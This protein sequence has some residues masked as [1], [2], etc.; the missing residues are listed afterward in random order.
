MDMRKTARTLLALCGIA[1]GC[2]AWLASAAEPASTNAAASGRSP[3]KV[4]D[5]FGDPTVAK[6]KGF[7]IK[8][9]E[10]EK[11]VDRTIAQA[12]ASGRQLPPEQKNLLE[13]SLLEQ[14]ISL[15]VLQGK[16]TEADRATG[17]VMA[18][19]Q[20]AEL[21]AQAGSDENLD[22][23]LN[24]AGAT[25]EEVLSKWRMA[26]TAEAVV[27]REI[28]VDVS[29]DDVKKSYE[30]NKSKFEQPEMVRVSHIALSTRDLVR[31]TELPE[32]EKAQKQKLAAELVKRARAGEDFA[33]L[34][35]EY[36]D[37][38]TTKDKGGDFVFPRD[39]TPKEFETAAFV[40]SSNQVSD[41][42]TTAYGFHVIKFT[43][44]FPS[45]MAVLNDEI[46][47]GPRFF[48]VKKSW[49][50]PVES[51]WKTETP[52]SIVRR[53]LEAQQRAKQL[54]AFLAELKKQADVQILDESLKPRT[55]AI[56]PVLSPDRPAIVPPSGNAGKK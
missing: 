42:I 28:K 4:S 51:T 53:N 16:A 46:L 45:R 29:D 39:T 2:G 12:A 35:K 5:L 26:G 6:G 14:I 25:R 50:G 21:K 1:A 55:N 40:M 31:G 22:R 30:E 36:S 15:Q 20:F 47:I 37:D 18:D 56:P 23:R 41:V 54:P 10:L 3:M 19:K 48:V 27:Q 44:K 11:E 13:Q 38:A 49:T 8:R 17:Y 34:A 52:A 32:A 33:K 7:E 9:G 43:E 24:A